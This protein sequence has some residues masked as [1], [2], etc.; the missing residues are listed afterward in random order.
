M[1]GIITFV[2]SAAVSTAYITYTEINPE[3]IAFGLAIGSCLFGSI[4]VQVIAT[5]LNMP[6]PLDD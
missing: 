4:L 3:P 6:N 1:I 2:L 5:R